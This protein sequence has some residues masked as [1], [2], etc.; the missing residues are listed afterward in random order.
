MPYDPDFIPGVHIPLP[1]MSDAVRGTAFNNGQPI[2]RTRFS[3]LFNQD[4]GFAFCTAHNINGADVIPEGRIRRRSF[5]LDPD[6]PSAFQVDNDRGY[7]GVPT[8]EDNPWD[9]GHMVRRRSLHWGDIDEAVRA[10]RESSFWTNI[11]PQHGRL[12]DTA[13]G[14]IEDFMLDVADD[15]GSRAAVFQAPVLTPHDPAHLNMP[16]EQ[17]IQIPAGFWKVMAV[18]H[19]GELRAA[20]FLVWQRDF[21]KPEP[22]TFDPVLEQIRVTTIEF[23]TG[24]SFPQILRDADPF[25]FSSQPAI[26]P[27]AAVGGT[28]GRRFVRPPQSRPTFI[29]S[30]QDILL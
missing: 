9:R 12:H 21:D 20:A 5:V 14:D 22:E 27:T 8:T 1:D 2:E 6:V 25:H 17:P 28:A 24:L 16:N 4:R 7:R 29:R 23:L 13:W 15:D 11:A 3:I 18:R 30:A 10:D 26:A 19:Q